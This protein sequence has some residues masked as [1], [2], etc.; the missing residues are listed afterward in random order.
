MNKVA[1]SG[2][3]F[4]PAPKVRYRIQNPLG[5]FLKSEPGSRVILSKP[6]GVFPVG[7]SGEVIKRR[8]LNTLAIVENPKTGDMYRG[9]RKGNWITLA[10]LADVAFRPADAL[11]GLQR[12]ISSG[13]K[14]LFNG[15]MI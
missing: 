14:R 6:L 13:G 12:L 11:K 3:R 7:R 1:F 8:D 5:K 2:V 10:N 15:R 4:N 9:I